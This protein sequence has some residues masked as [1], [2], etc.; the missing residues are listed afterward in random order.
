MRQSKSFREILERQYVQG[1]RRDLYQEVLKDLEKCQGPLPL[2]FKESISTAFFTEHQSVTTKFKPH[3]NPYRSPQGKSNP[4]K[5]Q[6]TN[7]DC[8]SPESDNLTNAHDFKEFAGPKFSATSFLRSKSKSSHT[9]TSGSEKN[10]EP[11]LKF[12]AS[13]KTVMTKLRALGVHI[14]EKITARE[15]K[16]TYRHNLMQR[17]PDRFT[18]INEDEYQA[19]T[20]RF[21]EFLH[22]WQL[23]ERGNSDKSEG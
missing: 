15:L 23:L 12:T 3:K 11:L 7:N 19:S 1:L 21:Q 13:Q 2:V 18:P 5:E 6:N 17:H 9:K 10:P 8:L 16:K 20:R 4:S 14:P 22:L